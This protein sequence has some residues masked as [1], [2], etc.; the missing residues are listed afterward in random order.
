MEIWALRSRGDRLWETQP[1]AASLDK[2]RVPL[3]TAACAHVY[4]GVSLQLP[5]P[6]R[7]ALATPELIHVSCHGDITKQGRKTT[8][9]T[10]L[11]S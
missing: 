7:G 10:I 4:K 5:L 3:A 8:V 2:A 11:I 1:F 6:R 9:T